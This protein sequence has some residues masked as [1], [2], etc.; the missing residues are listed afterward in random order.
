MEKV[1]IL[2]QYLYKFSVPQDLIECSLMIVESLEY[3]KTHQAVFTDSVLTP[4][5]EDA[6]E[7]VRVA[8]DIH[9]EYLKPHFMWANKRVPSE[10]HPR[11]YHPNSYVSGIIYLNDCN[12]R[13]WF[14]VP[15]FWRTDSTW[16]ISLQKVSE[17]GPE[18]IIHKEPSVGG[19]MIVFPSHLAHSVDENMSEHTRYTIGF[20]SFPCGKYLSPDESLHKL[21][22]KLV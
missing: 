21:N 20:N 18:E 9:F 2:P 12:S 17:Y 3:N 10:W 8:E 11:H 22:I 4:F 6:L 13:T 15:N 14:S 5:I 7:Q 1:S 19:T 16:G